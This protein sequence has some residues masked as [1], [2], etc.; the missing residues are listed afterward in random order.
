MIAPGAEFMVV[1]FPPKAMG[2]K[3]EELMNAKMVIPAN[4]TT[5]L[6]FNLER[7]ML[8]LVGPMMSCNVMGCARCH[9]WGNL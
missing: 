9:N 5:A 8:L 3:A 4:V 7:L 6:A 1:F 2:L